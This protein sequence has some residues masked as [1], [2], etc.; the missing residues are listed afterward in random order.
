L[1]AIAGLMM[2]APS[3]DEPHAYVVYYSPTARAAELLFGC[4]GAVVWRHRLVRLPERLSAGLPAELTASVPAALRDM[5]GRRRFWRAISAC[6]LAYLF[7]TLLFNYELTTEQVYLRACLLAVPLIVNLV[8]TP[9]SLLT[10]L[11]ACA[12]LRYLGRVSYALYLFHL[13]VRNVV[14]H[15]LPHAPL[16]LNALLT[17]SVSVLLAAASWRLL[18]SRVLRTRRADDD[19][20]RSRP[21][22]VRVLVPRMA[23][24]ALQSL[25]D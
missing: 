5:L 24:T 23:S 7:V 10:R 9:S 12:P 4:L 17:L 20:A 1:A 14:Y 18:E 8:G 3:P 16:Y 22:R 25:M 2:L 19:R 15:Y 21:R 11:I 6:V 13:L